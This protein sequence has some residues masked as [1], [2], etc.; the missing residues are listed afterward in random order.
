MDPPREGGGDGVG[1]N[2]FTID[3]FSSLLLAEHVPCLIS[4]LCCLSCSLGTLSLAPLFGE[5]MSGV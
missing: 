1:T 3:F 4:L 5:K 2:C